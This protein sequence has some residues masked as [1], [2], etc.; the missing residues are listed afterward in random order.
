MPEKRLD[1]LDRRAGVA[2]K[3]CGRV[4]QHVGQPRGMSSEVSTRKMIQHTQPSLTEPGGLRSPQNHCD[5]RLNLALSVTL[6]TLR[7]LSRTESA[8]SRS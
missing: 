8:P 5:R 2:P 1:I 4:A 3:L 6:S 7:R